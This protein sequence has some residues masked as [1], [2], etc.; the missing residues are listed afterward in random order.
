MFIYTFIHMYVCSFLYEKIY[1]KKIQETNQQ[2]YVENKN[3][4]EYIVWKDVIEFE[5]IF[6][7]FLFVCKQ[8]N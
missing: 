3:N 8:N 6:F 1:K 2:K 4:T 7:I 5:A